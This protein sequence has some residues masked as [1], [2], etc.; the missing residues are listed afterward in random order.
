MRCF[1]GRMYDMQRGTW[2]TCERCSGTGRVVYVYLS[3]TFKNNTRSEPRIPVL[4]T[5][6]SAR[7]F[8]D[9]EEVNKLG[10]SSS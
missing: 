8:V 6:S 1:E 9:R 4:L 10:K 3:S 7:V 5:E 2:V